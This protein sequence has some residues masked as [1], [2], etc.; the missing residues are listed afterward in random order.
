V[1]PEA[2]VS[3]TKA[4]KFYSNVKFITSNLAKGASSCNVFKMEHE[5]IERVSKVLTPCK[6][7][8][9]QKQ[10]RKLQGICQFAS[11]T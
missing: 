4:L 3:N 8:S 6:S 11:D 7:A 5:Y 10:M 1:S 2:L 9:S